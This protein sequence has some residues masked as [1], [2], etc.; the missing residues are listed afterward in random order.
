V[1]VNENR[2]RKSISKVRASLKQLVNTAAQSVMLSTGFPIG[3]LHADRLRLGASTATD[4]RVPYASVA[5]QP[6]Q[7]QTMDGCELRRTRVGGQ[8]TG[9]VR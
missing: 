1:R 5:F 4:R 6:N 3:Q 9:G 7:A 8:K 2:R